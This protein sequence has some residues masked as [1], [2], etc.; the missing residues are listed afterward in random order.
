MTD[1]SASP[2]TQ[3]GP[4]DPASASRA[5]RAR[6]VERLFKEHN[7]AL[8]GFLRTKLH[9]D[10]EARE[11]A[12][13]AYVRLLQLES[14]GVVSFLQAYLF[15]IAANIAVDRI[16]HQIVRERAAAEHALFF[17]EADE[18]ASVERRVLA[19]DELRCI[20]M[21]MQSMPPKCRMAF[22]MHVLLDRSIED[23][24]AEMSLSTRMVRY[25]IVRGLELCGKARRGTF[26]GKR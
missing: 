3:A 2:S 18:S 21:A 16:R 5:E 17:D 23:V 12:Q 4:G 19:R 25:Y 22:A 7:R 1:P 20:S 15:K 11:V 10:Q 9:N 6:L 26:N 13:E 24:A 14:P 8:I